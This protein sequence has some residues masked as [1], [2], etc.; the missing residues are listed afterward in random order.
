MSVH[1]EWIGRKRIMT[2]DWKSYLNEDPSRALI[3]V[4][5]RRIHLANRY[6]IT[7]ES[8]PATAQEV[9]Q[10]IWIIGDHYEVKNDN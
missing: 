10:F 6:D 9:S 3:V 8:R 4:S 1:V 7:V 5:G 2:T